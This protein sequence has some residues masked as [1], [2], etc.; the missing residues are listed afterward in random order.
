MT[1]PKRLRYANARDGGD[2]FVYGGYYVSAQDYDALAAQLA[3]SKRDAERY[4][5]L[6]DKATTSDWKQLSEL[7]PD[8]TEEEID[9]ALSQ[10]KSPTEKQE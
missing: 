6:R 5:W 3:E 9:D 4:R 10:S 1:P 8:R 2:C 7:T